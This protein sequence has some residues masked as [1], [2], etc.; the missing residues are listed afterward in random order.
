MSAKGFVAVAQM[1]PV[2]FLIFL[3]VKQ[4]SQK[5][6]WNSILFI[7][8]DDTYC[9]D[10]Y[11]DMEYIYIYIFWIQQ[12]KSFLSGCFWKKPG[13]LGYVGDYTTHL[14]GDYI[15]NHYKE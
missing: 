9:K 4:M 6:A 5:N 13:C 10:V 8:V 1:R 2:I 3:L 14:C 7:R 11:V 15:G 12:F